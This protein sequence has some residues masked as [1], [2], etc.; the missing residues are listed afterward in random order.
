MNIDTPERPTPLAALLRQHLGATAGE[1]TIVGTAFPRSEHPNV[2]RA[3]DHVLRGEDRKV[4]LI[5]VDGGD[6]LRG[7]RLAQLISL[8]TR[9]GELPATSGPVTWEQVPVDLGVEAPCVALGVYLVTAG[10]ERVVVLIAY[11]ASHDPFGEI[12]V[13]VASNMPERAEAWV[14]SIRTSA[15]ALSVY[16]GHA[17]TVGVDRYRT[18]LSLR[19]L[20]LKAPTREQLV[21]PDAVINLIERHTVRFARA[22]DRLRAMG[23]HLRRGILLHGPP[24]TGKT[25]TATW[26]AAEMKDRTTFVVTGAAL[27]LISEVC[28]LARLYEPSTVIL[29]DV[30]LVAEER[31]RQ[32]KGCNSVL[33]EL[34]NE[35]DGVGDDADILFLLTTN[36]PELLEPAL[37]ARPGRIDQAVEVPLPDD[38]CRRRLLALYRKDLDLRVDVD[39]L[40]ARTRGTSAAFMRELLRRAALVAVDRDSDIVEQVDVDGA[41]DEI[42]RLGGPLTKAL[43]GAS[44]AGVEE[45]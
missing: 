31:T 37:A 36:R 9:G 14:R 3:V 2:Q 19:F 26:I 32:S 44:R 41:L 28:A 13:D 4:E 10:D 6:G 45:A 30:D 16:R 7:P 22:R 43:L 24:G 38:D 34:L 21:L 33:F 29:E 40:V 42:V 25:L 1:P 27:G 20:A 17:L 11:P 35:M 18:A 12:R 15:R 39:V 8:R 5:G 23:R